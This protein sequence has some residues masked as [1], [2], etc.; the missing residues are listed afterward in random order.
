MQTCSQRAKFILMTEE[1]ETHE[2]YALKAIEAVTRQGLKPYLLR[3]V[4]I[5]V[6][7]IV[8]LSMIWYML[9]KKNEWPVAVLHPHIKKGVEDVKRNA[10][11]QRAGF[12]K[13][14]KAHHATSAVVI[15]FDKVNNPNSEE[16]T[17]VNNLTAKDVYFLEYTFPLEK[18]NDKNTTLE[19]IEKLYKQGVRT[20]IMTMSGP[21]TNIKDEFDS[22]AKEKPENER[23]VLVATVAS[24][25]KI[26][27][28]EMG[29]FR[30]YVRSEEESAVLSMH[31]E[32]SD[33]TKIYVFYVDDTYGQNASKNLKAS[34][35][36]LDPVLIPITPP[37]DREQIK[38]KI[39]EKILENYS[40]G[41]GEVAVIIGYGKMIANTLIELS[42]TGE[43]CVEINGETYL[44]T[45]K[46]TY[47]DTNGETKDRT[48]KERRREMLVVSTFTEE[49]WRPAFNQ[50]GDCDEDN[51]EKCNSNGRIDDNNFVSRI[52]A[53][54]LGPPDPQEVN[55]GVVFQF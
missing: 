7:F 11:R 42:D 16:V 28:K 47:K 43:P 23:P 21:V 51:K 3:W 50:E 1:K 38:K 44:E 40:G 52:H 37:H 9:A 24:A 20:F 8:G 35:D 46:E 34:L 49:G 6:V 45:Y 10:V 13:A 4:G 33:A 27:N 26:A 5:F 41:E 32:Y 15:D 22:W 29:I 54:G 12:E 30:Y 2:I 53:I 18:E 55:R 17:D 19:A 14:I 31:I 36:K 25:P 39:K 48:C